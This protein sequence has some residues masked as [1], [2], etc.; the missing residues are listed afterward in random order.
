VTE[1]AD[2][3]R[4]GDRVF[5]LVAQA[6]DDGLHGPLRRLGAAGAAARPARA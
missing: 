3:L 1:R 5:E 2:A 6:G 4:A